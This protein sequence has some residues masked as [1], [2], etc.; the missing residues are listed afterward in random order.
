[1]PVYDCRPAPE[2]GSVRFPCNVRVLDPRDGS[3]VPNVFLAATGPARLGR[4]AADAA[5]QPLASPVREKRLVDDG[6]GGKRVEYRN[7]RLDLYEFR[8]WV[9]VRAD[10]GEVVATSEGC[11]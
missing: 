1:M 10:T 7:A 5:G 3:R 6:R 11:P 2:P 4:F 9:A 8:P